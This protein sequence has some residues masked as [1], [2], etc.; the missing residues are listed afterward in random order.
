MNSTVIPGGR[1]V[2]R[3]E[4]CLNN[5]QAAGLCEVNPAE[6]EAVE[7]GLAPMVGMFLAGFGLGAVCAIGACA[8][9]YYL[10]S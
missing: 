5:Q 6:L 10:L 7:G 4:A 9:A 2:N 1:D 3:I 8:L